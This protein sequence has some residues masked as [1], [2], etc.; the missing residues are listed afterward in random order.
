MTE[1]DKFLARLDKLKT[2]AYL[3][4]VFNPFPLGLIAGI[5]LLEDKKY[6]ETG[7]NVLII[8]IAVLLIV[9]LL[10]LLRGL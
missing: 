8:S 9:F 2:I 3:A 7:K 6:K 4:A 10:A 1:I 5:L